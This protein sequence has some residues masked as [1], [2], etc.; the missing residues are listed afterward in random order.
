MKNDCV[1]FGAFELIYHL[2]DIIPQRGEEY[3]VVLS[4]VE[5]N[6]AMFEFEVQYLN[7]LVGETGE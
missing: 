2:F 1:L 3:F 6:R 5:N 7:C 4:I